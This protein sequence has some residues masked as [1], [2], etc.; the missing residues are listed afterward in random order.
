MRAEESLL[1]AISQIDTLIEQIN[2]TYDDSATEAENKFLME[3]CLLG[4]AMLMSALERKESRGAHFRG[5][6]PTENDAYQK[7]TIAEYQQ[8]E[9]HIWLEKAGELHED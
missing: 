7:Q 2:V 1:Q 6:Y 9:I 3:G 4:K 8:N 5:D